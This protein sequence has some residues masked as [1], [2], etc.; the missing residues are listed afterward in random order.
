[1]TASSSLH[2]GE[3]VEV[4]SREEILQTLDR[5]GQLDGL[6]FMPEMFEACG[7]RYRVF[8]RAH[9]TCDPPNGLQGRRMPSAVHLDEF[10]CDGAAHGG[11]QAKCLVFWKD[12]WLK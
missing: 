3:W 8:K 11:C 9:K 5:N 2:A 1:M 12:A 10:R 7:K 4:R 6:P